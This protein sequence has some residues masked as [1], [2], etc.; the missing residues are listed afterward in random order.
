MVTSNYTD[1]LL[2]PAAKAE[3]CD[4]LAEKITDIVHDPDTAQRLIPRTSA[5]GS[6]GRRS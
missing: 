4:F 2:D 3:W 5:S 6:T 1:L